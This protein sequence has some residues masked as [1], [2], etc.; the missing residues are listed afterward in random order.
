MINVLNNNLKLDSVYFNRYK[1]AKYELRVDNNVIYSF[2]TTAKSEE[3]C[4][5][6]LREKAKCHFTCYSRGFKICKIVGK[7]KEVIY[8][9]K[10]FT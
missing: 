1:K 6:I 7:E 4:I 3:E 10:K 2:V 9:E 8:K 5:E